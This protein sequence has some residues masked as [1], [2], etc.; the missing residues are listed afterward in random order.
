GP[1]RTGPDHAP[2]T[3]RDRL[4]SFPRLV[5]SLSLK[6]E[7]CRDSSPQN[8]GLCRRPPPTA[9]PGSSPHRCLEFP[10][11]KRRRHA[12]FGGYSEASLAEPGRGTET[13]PPATDTPHF[14][15]LFFAKPRTRGLSRNLSSKTSTN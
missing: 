11:R 5:F 10:A 9:G 15:G 8:R 14:R 6:F 7:A 4:A 1:E 2:Q 3:P 13:G 12:G